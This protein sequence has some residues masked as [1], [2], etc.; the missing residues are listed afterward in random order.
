MGCGASSAGGLGDGSGVLDLTGQTNLEPHLFHKEGLHELV[1]RKCELTEI[2][3]A[4]FDLSGL[5]TLDVAENHLT[6]LPPLIANLSSLQTLRCEENDLKELPPEIG[7]LRELR[8]LEAFKNQMTKLPAEISGLVSL[9][10]L[11]LFNC[12]LG[13]LPKQ[14]S[15]LRSLTELNVGDNRLP[16]L[17][18]LAKLTQLQR[19]AAHWNNLVVAPDLSKCV[20]LERIELDQ[21]QLEE[22]PKLGAHPGLESIQLA[23]NRISTI[24]Q[25][26]MDRRRLPKL[27]EL[28]LGDQQE[29]RLSELPDEV[30]LLR[31][32]KL[33]LQGNGLQSLPESFYA[34]HS[35]ETLNLVNN[36]IVELDVKISQMRKLKILLMQHNKLSRCDP[37]APSHPRPLTQVVTVRRLPHTMAEMHW[38][39]RLGLVGNSVS[40]TDSVFEQVEVICK[41]NGGK[42]VA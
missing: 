16:V 5:L 19:L 10:Y 34:I 31:V 42:I 23:K 4:V 3:S 37:T 32:A 33:D 1:L 14:L 6:Q 25:G 20:A 24:P 22:W 40:E 18:D 26:V 30:G 21:N 2:P 28:I 12:K 15:G 8:E 7:Q 17:P 9:E 35:L 13:R 36:S 11:N 41:K 29:G 27:R 39:E 38:L